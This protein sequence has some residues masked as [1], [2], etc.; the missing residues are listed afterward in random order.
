MKSISLFILFLLLISCAAQKV[1]ISVSESDPKKPMADPSVLNETVDLSIV[2]LK[3]VILKRAVPYY[4][5]EA[6]QNKVEGRVVVEVVIDEKGEVIFAHILESIPELDES[7][8]H[9]AMYC[10]FKPAFYKGK[11]V[12]VKMALSFDYALQNQVQ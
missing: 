3:P 8:K 4:P 10:L 1:Y 2:D 5:Q 11:P 12:K 9:T 7:A 6:R